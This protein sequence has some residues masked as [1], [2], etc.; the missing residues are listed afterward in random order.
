MSGIGSGGP[1][2]GQWPPYNFARGLAPND[3]V[4]NIR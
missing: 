3:R 2:V 4:T 1:G